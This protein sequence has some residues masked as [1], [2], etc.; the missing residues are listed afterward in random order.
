MCF[1]LRDFLVADFLH[2]RPVG[3]ALLRVQILN[4]RRLFSRKSKLLLDHRIHEGSVALKLNRDL[5]KSSDLATVKDLSEGLELRRALLFHALEH[6]GRID[7]AAAGSTGSATAN[8]T[9]AARA[10]STARTST[11]AAANSAA[12][13]SAGATAT[14]AAALGR[15]ILF[16]LCLLLSRYGEV[17]LDVGAKG[18]LNKVSALAKL[19]ASLA[20]LSAGATLATA[21]PTA[22]LAAATLG[23]DESRTHHQRCD[24]ECTIFNKFHVSYVASKWSG[25]S[26]GPVVQLTFER[27]FRT[28]RYLIDGATIAL[29]A[30]CWPKASILRIWFRFFLPP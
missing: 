26:G 1:F 24:D 4:L 17:F 8:S 7:L 2:D 14:A 23:E 29:R 9:A 21:S 5:L 11:T 25:R 27:F 13:G 16:E 3:F 28:Y 10:G 20:K 12:T 6:R 15:R 18:D 30:K 22:A 19:S